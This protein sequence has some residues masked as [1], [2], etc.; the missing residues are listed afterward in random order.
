MVDARIP[1]VSMKSQRLLAGSEWQVSLDQVRV[2]ADCLVGHSYQ[3]WEIVQS[4]LEGERGGFGFRS[5]EDGTVES[6][7]QYLKEERDRS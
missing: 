5:A 6:V 1:G 3:G 2:P 7:L 4:I